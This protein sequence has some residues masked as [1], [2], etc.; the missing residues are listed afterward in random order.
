M[1][2]EC[3]IG[4]L[5]VCLREILL[6]LQA[7]SALTRSVLPLLLLLLLL[8]TT[9]EL[10]LKTAFR[11]LAPHGTET[12]QPWR[13]RRGVAAACGVTLMAPSSLVMS[14]PMAPVVPTLTV[15]P[16]PWTSAAV[17]DMVCLSETRLVAG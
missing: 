16:S 5:K 15:P 11:G 7:S 6:V 9:V 13:L 2:S 12:G 17:Q 8:V 4:E 1:P 10:F 14:E 3:S